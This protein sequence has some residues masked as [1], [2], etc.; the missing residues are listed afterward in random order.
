MQILQPEH[1]KDDL[2]ATNKKG[3]LPMFYLEL[4][5]GLRKGEIT[6]LVWSDLDT[7]NKTI[8]TLAL[9]N[10]VDIKSISSMLRHYDAGFT[11]CTYP[12][13]HGRNKMRQ[14]RLWA[15]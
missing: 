14:H 2:D 1:S 3:L 6:A 5:T 12:T 9:Q 8:A 11:L 13:P 10:E 4:V 7:K 15:A